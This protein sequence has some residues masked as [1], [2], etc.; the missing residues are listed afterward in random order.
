MKKILSMILVMLIFPS[1]VFASESVDVSLN[2]SESFKVTVNCDET[3]SAMAFVY[4]Y[5]KSAAGINTLYS[6][7]KY[8]VPFG[9]SASFDVNPP[10]EGYIE[11]LA[12]FDRITLRPL[13]KSYAYPYIINIST[14]PLGFKLKSVGVV[15]KDGNSYLM[16]EYDL[17]EFQYSEDDYS[18][19][20]LMAKQ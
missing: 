13:C 18:A 10:E 17:T 16:N 12:V 6:V 19:V 7:K 11:K 4:T 3:V 15:E 20:S 9:A 2:T 5:K 14:E 8:D 1:C